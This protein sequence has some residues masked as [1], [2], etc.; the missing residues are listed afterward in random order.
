MVFDLA[1]F[2]GSLDL[3]DKVPL[4]L[5]FESPA[6]RVRATAAVVVAKDCYLVGRAMC[7]G[8]APTDAL[9][10]AVG[11]ENLESVFGAIHEGQE[12]EG[13]VELWGPDGEEPEW[14]LRWRLAVPGEFRCGRAT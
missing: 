5:E 11:W 7:L 6:A 8:F 14:L 13:D 2:V 12:C 10:E 4:A 9:L 3:G 1:G